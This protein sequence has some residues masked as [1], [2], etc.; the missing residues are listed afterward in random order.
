MTP[1]NYWPTPFSCP[2][3]SG[4]PSLQRRPNLPAAHRLSVVLLGQLRM[5]QPGLE[6]RALSLLPCWAGAALV[7]AACPPAGD[8]ASS[9]S[10]T[11]CLFR[12]PAP[13]AL[14]S[15]WTLAALYEARASTDFSP[16]RPPSSAAAPPSG[17]STLAVS[18]DGSK[19]VL[20]LAGQL[21]VLDCSQGLDLLCVQ[22]SS[23]AEAPG[24]PGLAAEE[25]AAMCISPNSSCVCMAAPM[26]ASSTPSSLLP[27]AAALAGVLLR[28]SLLPETAAGLPPEPSSPGSQGRRQHLQLDP[29][30][31]ALSNKL[32]AFRLAF[33]ALSG[34]HAWD[35]VQRCLRSGAAT[36][37]AS[38]EATLGMLDVM[39]HGL[40]ARLRAW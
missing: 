12:Q 22:Q 14:G 6:V 19:V 7:A 24:G 20:Q 13:P 1:L 40:D 34:R 11:L 15:E 26:P 37:W 33:A 9:S 38:T 31:Q 21:H 10:S 3:V 36:Q 28:V 32:D 17:A 39:F 27:E 8:P 30:S 18:E 5:P 29:A 4:T 35:C 25:P 2:Q 23:L 16:L